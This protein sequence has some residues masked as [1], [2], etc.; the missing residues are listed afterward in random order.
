MKIRDYLAK[1]KERI[2]YWAIASFVILIVALIAGDALESP[3]LLAL[4]FASFISYIASVA[5][6]HYSVRC[7]RCKSN[8]G[9]HISY[10]G[11]RKTL[12]FDTVN[13]CPFCGVHLDESVRT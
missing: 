4:A 8:I 3:S 7:P 6:H 2:G 11:V 9:R 12:F 5:F 10:F 1:R 13:Y